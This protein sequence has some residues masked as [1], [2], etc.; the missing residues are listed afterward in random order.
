MIPLV[1]FPAI[2]AQIEDQNTLPTGNKKNPDMQFEKVYLH[3]DRLYFTSGEDIWF[4]AYLVDASTNQLSSN[5]TNLYIEFISNDSKIIKRL[6]LKTENGVG[7]GDIHIAD[8]LSSG[9]YLIRAYTNW[10]RN[11]GDVFFFKKEI[12]IE[13]PKVLKSLNK[14]DNKNEKIDLQFFP[15]SGPL[16]D[17]VYT[18]V[19]FKAVNSAGYGCN[20]SGSVISS[21]GDTVTG[22]TSTHLGM[23]SFYILPRKGFKYYASGYARD[24]AAFRVELPITT[25]TGYSILLSDIN[26]DFFRVIVKTN[27]ETLNM[28]P[29]NEV[30][31]VGTSHNSLCVTA[32]VKVK[33]INNPVILSKKEFPE[34]VALITLIDTLG[35]IYCERPFYVNSKEN[36]HISIIP[37]HDV[38]AAREIVTLHIAVKDSSDYPVAANLSVSVVDGNI[39]EG[40]DKKPDIVCWLL[41]ESELRGYIE[42]PSYY[43][44]ATKAD[45]FQSLD[46][47]LLTQGWRNYVWNSL[48]E[49]DINFNFPA[50]EGITVS[51]RL[52]RVLADKPIANANIFL[53][54]LGNERPSY[55]MTKTDSTGKY[56]FA[57]LDFTGPHNLL[58]FATDKNNNGTGLILLDTLFS[59]HAPVNYNN[60]PESETK[61]RSVFN[62]IDVGN[63]IQVADYN[64]ISNYK[65]ATETNYNTLKKY[66]L[67]DT[68]ALNE[69]EVKAR[70]QEKENSDGHIRLYGLPDFSLKV[71][72]PMST[73]YRD[74]IQTLQSRV[75]GF[76]ITGDWVNGYKFIFH[77]Q[78][79][80]P[81]FLIDGKV[82][83]YESIITLPMD[84]IDKIEVIKDGGK[85][86]LYGFRGSFG[87][88]SIL[89]KRGSNGQPQPVLNLINQRVYGYYQPRTFYSPKYDV[90]KPEYEKPDLKTTIHWEPNVVTDEDGNATISFYNSDSKTIIKVDAEGIAEPGIPVAGKIGINVK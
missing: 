50:E 6:V 5:S 20:A 2:S 90:K 16:I 61:T 30:L 79:G 64:Y 85:L 70:R 80:E 73:G 15:E 71:T 37:D 48:P 46:N 7:N 33:A 14:P 68:V 35:K 69:V 57:G 17:N 87:V 3:L 12:V 84:A 23:G 58:V 28:F 44:D 75:A 19:G 40:F 67:T 10:M 21:S 76:Y 34:G 41:L 38:Y 39:V 32:R 49:K 72:E 1:L 22:F 88:I 83:D 66:H 74:A 55:K 89:T 86:S 81:L 45:R 52:R 18:R 78:K 51:G 77:G 29:L 42:Q 54:R 47:L 43:F 62:S 53:A 63:L 4:K 8:T 13:N 59:D 31:L 82:V 65:K 60:L 56:S 26:K 25:E 9:K 27:Q 36:Y 24:G 11:F